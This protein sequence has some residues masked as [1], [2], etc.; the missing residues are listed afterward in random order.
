MQVQDLC[1]RLNVVSGQ[2]GLSLEAQRNATIMSMSLLRANLASK[3]MLKVGLGFGKWVYV[4]VFIFCTIPP[5]SLLRA[6]LASKRMLKV[7]LGFG[8]WV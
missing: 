4:C 5:L 7:G 3:R 1:G 8:K 6:N 2:D